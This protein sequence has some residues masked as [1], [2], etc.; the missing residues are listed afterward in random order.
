ML[1]DEIKN[2]IQLKKQVKLA[3]ISLSRLGYE[4]M[5]P[6]WKTNINKLGSLILNQHSVKGCNLKKKEI[7]LKM[8]QKTIQ[9]KRQNP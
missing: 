2:K 9:V 4:T 3:R 7:N 1:N 8:A 6:P 5:I